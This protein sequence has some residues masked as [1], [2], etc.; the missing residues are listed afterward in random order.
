MYNYIN[1]NN[2]VK[3]ITS[4]NY[5]KQGRKQVS[6]LARTLMWSLRIFLASVMLI[7]TYNVALAIC[8]AITLNY[9]LWLSSTI[10]SIAYCSIAMLIILGIYLYLKNLTKSLSKTI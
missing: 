7:T 9:T 3:E 6:R 8:D 5:K 4:A 2:S 1:N 10:A